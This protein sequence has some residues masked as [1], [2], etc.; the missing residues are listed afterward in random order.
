MCLDGLPTMLNLRRRGLNTAGFC[1]IHDKDLESI[2]HALFHCNHPKQT[3]S[4]WSDC[5][6]NLYSPT[7]DFIGITSQIMEKGSSTDLDLFFMAAWSIWGNRNN[8]T[9]N[10]ASYP[11]TQVWE[12]AKW[13]LIDFTTSN[14]P[15]H[16]SHPMVRA[17]W[18]PPLLGFHKINVDGATTNN[19]EH[20]SI[21]VIIRDHTKATI[22]AFNKLLP[23][24]FPASITKAFALLQGVLFVA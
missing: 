4:C 13:S 14:L 9:H 5:P 8:A 19:R 11:P 24:A 1:Q 18:S 12:I 20:Y 3:W 6:M 16:P 21:R 23:S 2:S 17:H 15:D 10:Y 22:G 7:Q